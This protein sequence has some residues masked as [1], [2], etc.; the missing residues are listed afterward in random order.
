MFGIV[1]A[2]LKLGH[3]L[4]EDTKESL[5]SGGLAVFAKEGGDA[6][7]LLHGPLLQGLQ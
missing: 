5:D 7:E 6:G 3:E 2:Y 4:S 1:T